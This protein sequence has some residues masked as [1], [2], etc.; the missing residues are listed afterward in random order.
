[1]FGDG[2]FLDGT[3]GFVFG[4]ADDLV[5]LVLESVFQGS[6]ALFQVD[7]VLDK[8]S[9]EFVVKVGRSGLSIF[10]TADDCQVAKSEGLQI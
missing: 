6:H 2:G 10:G 9:L 7:A 1:L 5:D 8:V 3:A 4:G